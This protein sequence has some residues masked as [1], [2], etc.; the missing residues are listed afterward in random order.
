[1]R[2]RAVVLTYP[3]HFLLTQLTLRSIKINLPEIKEII[4]VADDCSPLAWSGYIDH[5]RQSYNVKILPVS[6]TNLN[7]ITPG[8]LRQQLVK[9][10]IDEII[11]WPEFFLTDGDIRF[12]DPVPF[13]IVPF[14]YI[15]LTEIDQAQSEYVSKML[16]IDHSPFTINDHLVITSNS[17]FRDTNVQW[18]KGLRSYVENRFQKS[19]IDIHNELDTL[20]GVSEWELVE[21]YK[22]HVLGIDLKFD[23]LFCQE[24]QNEQRDILDAKFTTCWCVDRELGLDWWQQQYVDLGLWKILPNSK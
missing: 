1:M 6:Q 8:W 20:Q 4:V 19:L 5:C 17:A 21:N 2:S 15:N 24:F 12:D 9:M 11:D 10:Y 3:G 7:Q 23:T 22:K 13:N 18:W 16:G 14:N